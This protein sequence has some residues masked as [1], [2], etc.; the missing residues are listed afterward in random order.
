MSA[1]SPDEGEG[2]SEVSMTRRPLAGR[3]AAGFVLLAIGLAIVPREEGAPQAPLEPEPRGPGAIQTDGSS[4][5]AKQ[6]APATTRP[7]ANGACPEGMALVDGDYCPYVYQHCV[8]WR[9]PVQKLQCEEFA[10]S[11]P[12]LMQTTHERFCIDRYEWPNR[13][14]AMPENMA[15]WS[16]AKRACEG[17]GKRLCAD[18]EWTL[19]CE[20]SEHLPYPYGYRRNQQVCNIDRPYLV[21]D[22]LKVYDR[23]P[24]IQSAELAR[25]DQRE[26]SGARDSCVSPYGVH[27]MAGNVDEWVVNATQN[28]WPYRSGLKGGYWGPVR[29]RCRPMTTGHPESFRYYQIGFRCCGD[30]GGSA[31]EPVTVAS[32]AGG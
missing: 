8:R 16:E 17:A 11:G 26:P 29:T 25:L 19:A 32:A 13:K 1:I 12:C 22:D 14:G 31:H 30:T 15:S 10:P 6:A 20:G 2:S 24:R 21:P 23:D 28:G 27:D 18:S 5:A 9:D 3:A 4:V 7:D